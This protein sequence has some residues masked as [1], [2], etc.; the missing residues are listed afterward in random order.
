LSLA[1]AS[2]L[3][4]WSAIWEAIAAGLSEARCASSSA[5]WAGE[6]GPPTDDHNRDQFIDWALGRF[7]LAGLDV[8]VV[9]SV[10]F[11]PL[12][13]RCNDVAGFAAW[14]GEST[15][16]LICD[17][18][19]L[20]DWAEPATPDCAGE[21]CVQEWPRSRGALVLHEY[22]HAWLNTHLDQTRQTEYMTHVGVTTW[23]DSA[24]PWAQRGVEWAAETIAWGLG[25]RNLIHGRLGP[26]GPLGDPPCQTVADGFTI[27][28]AAEPLNTCE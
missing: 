3:A 25:D 12:D 16:I 9:S 10:E 27:L 4:C 1:S 28:T 2:S 23:N 5:C 11:N 17:N 6:P 20:I 22:G 26:L 14:S 13:P 15:D 8:P 7:A 18:A 19:D 21:D 24:V